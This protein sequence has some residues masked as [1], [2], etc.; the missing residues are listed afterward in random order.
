MPKHRAR[1]CRGSRHGFGYWRGKHRQLDQYRRFGC[2]WAV[3]DRIAPAVGD[4]LGPAAGIEKADLPHQSTSVDRKRESCLH[5]PEFHCL[6]SPLARDE[7][8]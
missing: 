1:S 8:Y 3:R 4:V 7:I 5:I 2:G 6:Q